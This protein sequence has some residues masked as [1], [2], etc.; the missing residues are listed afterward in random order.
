MYLWIKDQ[1]R[2]FQNHPQSYLAQS[3]ENNLYDN[4]ENRNIVCISAL[5]FVPL[6][7][8][9]IFLL[10]RNKQKIIVRTLYYGFLAN[11]TK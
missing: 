5:L 1:T 9:F 2:Q 10:V 3:I 4:L 8:F 6:L 11:Y 7:I